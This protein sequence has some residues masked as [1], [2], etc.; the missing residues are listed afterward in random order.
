MLIVP[1]TKTGEH[2]PVHNYLR[3]ILEAWCDS[4]NFRPFLYRYCIVKIN[5][6][7]IKSRWILWSIIIFKEDANS[8]LEK[9][10]VNEENTK[11]IGERICMSYWTYRI[12]KSKLFII[13]NQDSRYTAVELLGKIDFSYQEMNF[14]L[15]KTPSFACF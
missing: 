12:F 8:K 13:I 11:L 4:W 9:A 3:T 7:L 1:L 14:C 6:F 5:Y 15:K 10:K 2:L